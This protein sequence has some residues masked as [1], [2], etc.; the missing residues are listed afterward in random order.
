MDDDARE[1]RKERKAARKRARALLEGNLTSRQH[2]QFR[3]KGH[4]DVW[5]S[6][7]NCYRIA[8]EFPYNVR[9]AG[10]A[11]RSKIYFCLEAEDPELPEEDVLLAQKLLLEADE[12]EFLRVANMAYKPFG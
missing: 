1:W 6:K 12:G 8:S 2:K 7:G 3:K 11:K 9:L 10:D 4:F 5:G